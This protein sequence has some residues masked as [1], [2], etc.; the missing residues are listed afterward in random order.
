MRSPGRSAAAAGWRGPTARTRPMSMPPEPVTGLCSF[1]RARTIRSTSA[2]IRAGSRPTAPSSCRKLAASTLSASTAIE[3]SSSP[4]GSAGSSDVGALRERRLP[5]RRRGAGRRDP[6]EER[7][8][9]GAG[10]PAT[11]RGRA[12][13]AGQAHGPPAGR[14]RHASASTRTSAS[15]ARSSVGHRP[16]RAAQARLERER[17]RPAASR[18]PAPRK[19]A[20][21]W[22]SA[23]S[24]S[25]RRPCAARTRARVK[26]A[27]ATRILPAALPRDLLELRRLGVGLAEPPRASATRTASGRNAASHAAHSPWRTAV[28]LASRSG[29]LGAVERARGEPVAG[30]HRVEARERVA[31]EPRALGNDDA[32]DRRARAPRRAGRAR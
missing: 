25:S 9:R 32:V 4:S 13:A 23:A 18:W 3:S 30:L 15:S 21:A 26:R 16:A 14:L 20:R 27:I 7:Y 2:P 28:S 24:A 5:G 1:P 17:V 12:G 29:V 22:A 6:C 19:P 31:P 11:R 10:T 8:G